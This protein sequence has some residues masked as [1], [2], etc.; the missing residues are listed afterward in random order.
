[1][2]EFQVSIDQENDCFLSY[3]KVNSINSAVSYLQKH[4]E[5]YAVKPLFSVIKLQ[6]KQKSRN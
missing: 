5:I 4:R 6:M 2:E 3:Q 1:M